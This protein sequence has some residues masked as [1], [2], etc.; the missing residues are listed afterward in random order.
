MPLIRPLSSSPGSLPRLVAGVCLAATLLYV[1]DAR[2]D[3]AEW[4]APTSDERRLELPEL[5]PAIPSPAQILG[6][7]LGERFHHHHQLL[8]YLEALAEASPRVI[9]ESYGETYE[10]R[11][12][13]LA[14]LSSPENLQRL[15][16]IR[17]DR[18]LLGDPAL[19]DE[20]EAGDLMART[21]AVLWLGYG[22][23]GNESSS[24]EAALA[25]AYVLAAGTGDFAR[26]LER[27]VVIIDPLMNPDGRE[28]YV[29][30][31]RSLR[32]R[33]PNPDGESV[34]H[35]EPW[36]GGRGNHYGFDLNRDWAWGTQLETR[37]RLRAFTAW[38]P[39]V[40]V[41][42][43]EM[44]ASATYFFPPPAEP[45]HPRIDARARHWLEVFGR[46]NASAFDQIGWTYY[47]ADQFDLF[48]PAYGD[49]YPTLRGG[50]GMTYEVGGGGRAGAAIDLTGG[51]VRTLA[52]RVTRHL[53]ASLATVQTAAQHGPQMVE[54]FHQRRRDQL[55]RPAESFVWSAAAAEA[56]QLANVLDRHGIRVERIQRQFQT[57]ALPVDP[58]QA[59]GEITL[60][61]GDYVVDTA[62]PLGAL[63]ASL[64]ERQ[65]EISDQF[66][67]QQRERVEE[68]RY[69]QF[70]DITAW[71]LPLVYGVPAWQLDRRLPEGSVGTAAPPPEETA[72]EGNTLG[73][74]LPP[75]G[76]EGYRFAW[77]LWREGIRLRWA[78]E[79]FELTQRA[80]PAGS[81]LVVAE[82]QPGGAWPHQ[83]EWISRLAARVPLPI[84]PVTSS[85]T[86]AGIDLGSSDFSAV[87]PPRIG[88]LRG[89][90]LS[91]TSF[92]SLW[93]LLDRD[94]EAPHSVLPVERLSRL[95]L[96]EYDTLLLPDGWRFDALD[97]EALRHLD[98]WVRD[99]G[100][101]ITIGSASGWLIES[102]F[103]GDANDGSEAPEE[104][105]K[106]EA[107]EPPAATLEV[108]GA[109]V[110]SESERHPTTR[111]G[112]ASPFWLF[113]GAAGEQPMGGEVLM[114]V[115]SEPA[116]GFAWNEGRE[117]LPGSPLVSQRSMGSG[118]VILFHQDPAFRLLTR[119]TLPVLLDWLLFGGAL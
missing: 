80:F 105:A 110:A 2:S 37:H 6:S 55:K 23:H 41:D 36:P 57:R 40:T 10:G 33:L 51:R 93:H 60:Q 86:R 19:V 74:A 34:E 47:V 13:T 113:Y 46:G 28:R 108:P 81:L 92:G 65:A 102:G 90:G 98:R 89:E 17:A 30:A 39:Q 118:A 61:P 76:V 69:A 68:D 106:A 52:D 26:Q 18:R 58:R 16:E 15:D 87:A 112:S 97:E 48:Y 29:Q 3:L 104:A 115:A 38:E 116:V 14:I 43:H 21:P 100:R 42:L 109:L 9:V 91:A 79:P 27:L 4:L 63:A 20:A 45:V 67:R 11:P 31:Y 99:G 117:R 82:D 111:G 56:H 66:I 22:V 107:E 94:L 119:G 95:A 25:T 96:E 32:G 103:L 5:D 62:Q 70:Y 59:P 64:L 35:I 78:T 71:S 85:W 84:E 101:L 8:R 88:L 77:N 75:H 53:A 73:F 50:I 24:A 7:P 72:P 49:S 44:G 83:R 12:L 1:G 54:E 114:R